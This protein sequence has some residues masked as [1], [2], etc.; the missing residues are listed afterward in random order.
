M[1]FEE[2]NTYKDFDSFYKLCIDYIEL[3]RD[4]KV[5]SFDEEEILKDVEVFDPNSIDS[6]ETYFIQYDN[7]YTI[8]V[9]M[10]ELNRVENIDM[11][12]WIKTLGNKYR[13]IRDIVNSD[14]CWSI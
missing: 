13:I 8:Y 7:F 3:M 12:D 4:L 10:R 9:S 6:M 14:I 5:S 2:L 1:T 11:S